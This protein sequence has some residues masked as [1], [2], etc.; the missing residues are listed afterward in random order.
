MNPPVTS[1]ALLCKVS[2]RKRSMGILWKFA[3]NFHHFFSL[4]QDSPIIDFYPSNFHVDLNGKKYQWQGKIWLLLDNSGWAVLKKW[5]MSVWLLSP[6]S[7]NN[8]RW[9]LL[10]AA[11]DFISMFPP[12]VKWC[13][14]YI[15][16]NI[17][18]SNI[19]INENKL[20]VSP[21]PSI[22]NSHHLPTA[23]PAEVIRCKGSC[24]SVR[25]LIL[26]VLVL[27]CMII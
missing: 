9:S 18:K 11:V 2:V 24:S 21:P 22:S 15:L 1:L 4:I 10:M 14:L 8:L 12:F 7:K 17:S 13:M 23:L 20:V 6:L 25:S 3:A 26:Q 27:P 16:N 19:G 5:G